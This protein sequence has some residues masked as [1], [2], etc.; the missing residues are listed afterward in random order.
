MPNPQPF[1][2]T[3]KS[4]GMEAENGSCAAES[5]DQ[6]AR[7]LEHSQNMLAFYMLERIFGLWLR[8]GFG[9]CLPAGF[10]HRKEIRPEFE[11]V[12]P[13][14]FCWQKG[15]RKHS[16]V[17]SD[18]G[19]F[20]QVLKF[21]NIARPMVGR[22][23]IHCCLRYFLNPFFHAPGEYLYEVQHQLTYVI[24]AFPQG[25]EHDWEDIQPIVQ[26]TTEFVACDHLR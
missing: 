25:R 8:H 4:V 6:P 3:A 23:C 24:L 1:H 22:E 19:P 15:I 16:V 2:Q 26:I 9:F 18:H 14:S 7:S 12:A 20:N 5:A 21:P 11:N 10:L 17:R 13:R